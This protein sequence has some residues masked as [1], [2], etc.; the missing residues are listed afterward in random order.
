MYEKCI[1][2]EMTIIEILLLYLYRVE[3]DIILLA[4]LLIST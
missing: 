2:L 1:S 3:C 4:S